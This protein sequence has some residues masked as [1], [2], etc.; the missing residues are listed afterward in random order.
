M[1]AVVD[2]AV[3]VVDGAWDSG[4][5]VAIG[6]AM[7]GRPYDVAM[8]R[9]PTAPG[10]AVVG[11]VWVGTVVRVGEGRDNLSLLR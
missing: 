10:V 6:G 2:D 3:T 9:G 5:G 4:G 8:L 11:I 7:G 1:R